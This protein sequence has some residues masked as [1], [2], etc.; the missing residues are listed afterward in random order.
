MKIAY[1]VPREVYETKMSRVRFQQIEAIGREAPVVWTGPGWTAPM[2]SDALASA[3]VAAGRQ[4]GYLHAPA[5]DSSLSHVENLARIRIGDDQVELAITY[6]VEGLAGAHCPVAVQFNEAF[7]TLKTDALVKSAGA[8]LVIFH[9]A[10]DLPRYWFWSE[11]IRRVHLPHC[12]DTRVYRPSR[13]VSG[14]MCVKDIDIVV[15]G[16]LNSWHY[17]LR[18]RLM[19]LAVEHFSRRNYKVLVLPHPGYTAPLREGTVVGVEFARVLSRAKLVFTCSMRWNY[20]LAKYSEIASCSSLA[21]ADLPGERHDFF[22]QTIL[23]VEPWM[24][25]AKIIR[26]VEEM[27]DPDSE[28]ELKR[29]TVRARDLTLKEYTMEHYAARFRAAATEHIQALGRG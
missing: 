13:Y 25:D 1:V 12:A 29:R 26:S 28:A 17:P 10:N 18:Y 15:A 11:T 22:K 24:S 8:S 7:N 9:H 19:R 16:N 14:K 20:A 23:N 3:A 6:D 4:N 5:W 2:A 27:L 21:V